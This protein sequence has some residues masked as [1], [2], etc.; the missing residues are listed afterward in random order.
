MSTP[1]TEKNQG[2]QRKNQLYTMVSQMSWEL[3]LV[4]FGVGLLPCFAILWNL[5]D[6]ILKCMDI[7]KLW[8]DG[9]S[10]DGIIMKK[11]DINHVQR[12]K[13]AGGSHKEFYFDIEYTLGTVT[14]IVDKEIFDRH[15]E[16]DE[17]EVIYMKFER[18][19]IIVRLKN[20]PN[21]VINGEFTYS[22]RIFFGIVFGIGPTFIWITMGMMRE[23]TLFAISIIITMVVDFIIIK[24][25]CYL[26]F[27]Y[28]A[29]RTNNDVQHPQT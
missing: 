28:N 11:Y 16:T 9:I 1:T 7:S 18:Q 2:L 21:A 8:K 29:W 25:F 23:G 3:W 12:G 10:V 27:N 13:G 4:A 17:I 22:M 5:C 20:Y 19:K 15:Q 26:W 6:T 14:F 24:S